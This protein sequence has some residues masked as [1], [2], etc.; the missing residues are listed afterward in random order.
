[1]YRRNS[2][3]EEPFYH[4]VAYYRLSKEDSR[5]S[6]SDSIANQDEICQGIFLRKYIFW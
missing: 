6:E 3:L 1:M 4:A 2:S 5:R